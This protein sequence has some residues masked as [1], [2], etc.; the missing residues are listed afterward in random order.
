MKKKPDLTNDERV[1]RGLH[2]AVGQGRVVCFIDDL[3]RPRV[4]CQ[5]LAAAYRA[6]AAEEDRETE[7]LDWIEAMVGDVAG[8]VR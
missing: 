6:M 7:A 4:T 3:I 5:D 8:E 2:G 1:T